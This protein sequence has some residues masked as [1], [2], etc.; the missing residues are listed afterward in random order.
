[1]HK[2][3]QYLKLAELFQNDQ[4]LY[5]A[6]YYL[7]KALCMLGDEERALPLARESALM[8]RGKPFAHGI[9]VYAVRWASWMMRRH[10]E[11]RQALE[12]I[13]QALAE[14]RGVDFAQFILIDR[15]RTQA[16][17]GDWDQ[18]ERDLAAFFQQTA[19]LHLEYQAHAAACLLLG[20]LHERRGDHAKAV[21]A[22]RDGTY[23]AWLTRFP[24]EQ[25]RHFPEVPP[26]VGLL[27]QSVLG[28]LSGTTTDAEAMALWEELLAEVGNRSAFTLQVANTLKFTPAILQNMWRNEHGRQ[29]A[30]GLAYLRL[31]PR[32]Y[33]RGP[34]A[35]AVTEKFR[36][37]VFL[38]K[39]SPE[40]DDLIWNMTRLAMDSY[41]AGKVSQPQML[42][43]VLSWKGT[44]GILGWS[45]VAP[46]LDPALRGPVAYV[47]GMRYLRLNRPQ[48]AAAF[49]R[50]ATS[51]APPTT[52]L[53]RLAQAELARLPKTQ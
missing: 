1:V 9:T 33:Y 12:L 37:D 17:L 51:D 15:A 40:Q 7:S 43:L 53:H 10:G 24:E 14:H 11:A 2:L 23:P 26:R 3:E 52:P 18:A 22:W 6:R 19:P 38:G 50:T 25:R 48:D 49:F 8:W 30:E 28:S 34:A 21:Q 39:P 44:T 4:H 27:F 16:A 5:N 20:F 46:S 13:D 29:L 42:G 45:G 35:L 36:Q 41:Y 47:L 31:P 32:D